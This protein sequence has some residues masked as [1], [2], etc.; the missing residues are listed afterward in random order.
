MITHTMPIS[1][2]SDKEYLEKL[3]IKYN[4]LMFATVRRYLSNSTDCEDIVQ[5]AIVSLCSKINLLQNLPDYAVSAYIVYTV[6][7]TTINHQRHQ[8]VVSKH[9]QEL[10]DYDAESSDISPHDYLEL[11]EMKAN[12]VKVWSRLSEQDQELLYR[13]YIFGQDNAELARLFH[14]REDNLRVKLARARK[15]A[16]KLLRE[17]G[18]NEEP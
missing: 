6:K 4:R 5:D 1:E 17:E 7:N 14:C 2:E 18:P 8:A 12:L 9:V 15:R 3:Y 10:I 11:M 13:K 16:A